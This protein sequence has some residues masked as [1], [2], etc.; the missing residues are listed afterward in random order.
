M[1]AAAWMSFLPFAVDTCRARWSRVEL[2]R[3]SAAASVGTSAR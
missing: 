1:F 2:A 3:E